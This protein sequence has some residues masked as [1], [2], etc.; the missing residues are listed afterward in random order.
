MRSLDLV[1][2]GGF[3]IRTA[4][5]PGQAE[6]AAPHR[7]GNVELVVVEGGAGRH[8]TGAGRY[9]LARGDVFVIPV[10]MAHRYVATDR[11]H[12]WNIG[13]DPRRLDL[14]HARLARLPGYRALV[15]LEPRLRDRQGFAGHLR[16]A[17][18]ELERLLAAIADLDHEL[19]QRAAGWQDAATAQLQGILL[20]LARA[21]AAQD[22][23]AARAALRLDAV[24]ARIDRD[25]SGDLALAGLAAAAGMS[26]STLQRQ[27]RLLAGTSVA[28]YVI[29]RR[30]EAACRLLDA[31]AAVGEAAR[32]A[33]FADPGYF[34]RLFR[35]R[36]GLAPGAYR[37]RGLR[38]ST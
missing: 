6:D 18:A 34:A 32:R 35:R 2:P 16:L 1:A 4:H 19:R 31:G 38:P 36:R 24:L 37:A 30:L 22:T 12:L 26:A 29:A 15:D 23:P 21:Y 17:G 7:H 27:F 33:G 10:G 5:V 25:L 20:R 11:L 13:Y 28:Q 14:P 9:R 3:P 8:D